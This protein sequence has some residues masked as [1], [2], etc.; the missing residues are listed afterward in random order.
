MPGPVGFFSVRDGARGGHEVAA[1]VLAG[2]AEFDRVAADLGVAVAELLAAGQPELLADEVDAGDFLGDAVLH[3]EAG[4]DL[5]EGDG[6]VLADEELAGAGAEVA[7]FLEDGL[8]GFVEAPVLLLGEERGRGF[9]DELLVAA[10]E[11]AVAGGDHHHVAV[12]V[13][14]ALGLDVARGVQEALDE[15]LAA[16]EGGD[17]LA[18][19]GF[20]QFGDFLAG[21]GHLDAASAAAEGRL[22][23]DGQAELVHELEDFLGGLHRVGGA[24]DLRGADLFGDVAGLDLVAQGGDRLGGGADPGDAGVDDL[25]GE[26]GVLGQEAVAGVDGVGAG[27][28]GR[29]RSACPSRGRTRRR[30]CRPGRRPRRRAGRAGRRGPD[31][32]RPPR[33]RCL[34][35]GR[36]G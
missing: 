33:R 4:V 1:R 24:G 36:R 30:C 19:G 31:P 10:L 9:L 27:A 29:P 3:L 22:D 20:E 25:G 7:G 15:A 14:E 21:A 18:D 32:R 6:A 13:G 5:E 23:G 11:R 2:D 8:G 35:R 17:G 26:L 16:A 12:G 28:G 34:H